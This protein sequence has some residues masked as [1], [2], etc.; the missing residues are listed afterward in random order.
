LLLNGVYVDVERRLT[1]Q[2]AF[3]IVVLH[4]L[5]QGH[6]SFNASGKPKHRGPR[7]KS[8]IGALI[9]DSLY[10][11][12]MEGKTV[13]QLLA[14][15]GPECER[16]RERLGGVTASLL[17][18]LQDLHDRIGECLPSLFRHLV[19]AG[20]HR[21]AQTFGLSPR[22]ARQWVAYHRLP[23]PQIAQTAVQSPA[24]QDVAPAQTLGRPS[25]E[26]KLVA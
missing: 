18:E 5:N 19:V 8:A 9:P 25:A 17:G 23:G 10:V 12:S 3:D 21:I 4:L 14:A 26:L 16:L 1:N 6:R 22:V 13:Q 11:I 20:G 15:S 7:G 24:S 2:A